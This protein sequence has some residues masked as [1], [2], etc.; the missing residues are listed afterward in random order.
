MK[1]T[2]TGTIPIFNIIEKSPCKPDME[3]RN[4][5]IIIIISSGSSSNSIRIT[6]I[7]INYI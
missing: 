3:T 2:A 7:I 1:H 5:L 4:A 6:I